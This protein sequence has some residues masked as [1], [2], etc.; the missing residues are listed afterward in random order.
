M[1][2]PR[3]ILEDSITIAVVGASRDPAKEAHS[4]PAQMLRHGWRI[5]PVNPYATDAFAEALNT[6]LLMPAEE[7][8]LRMQ[9]LRAQVTEHN[10]FRWAGLLLTETCRL[11]E[12]TH[13]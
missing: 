4:V 9:R 1:R 13:S 5:I 3:Q 11:A 7:Q 2:T 6:A 10:I 12:S 8:R